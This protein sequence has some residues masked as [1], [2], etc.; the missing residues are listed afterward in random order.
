MLRCGTNKIGRGK[1]QLCRQAAPSP[2]AI[3]KRIS[4]SDRGS[5]FV[6]QEI[7]P[8]NTQ[9]SHAVDDIVRDEAVHALTR[10]K[11]HGL[12]AVQSDL[13]SVVIVKFR[14]LIV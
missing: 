3:Q 12:S 5:S 4:E 6:I 2:V 7:P 13:L 9:R 8:G 11:D 10:D 14:R 1:E